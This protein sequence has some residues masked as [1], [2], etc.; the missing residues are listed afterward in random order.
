MYP[1]ESCKE[2]EL[3]PHAVHMPLPVED[4][5]EEDTLNAVAGC[6]QQMEW[7]RHRQQTVENPFTIRK[8]VPEAGK[9]LGV[10]STRL[11]L[12]GKDNSSDPTMIRYNHS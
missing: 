2:G 6:H 11:A 10:S 12:G 4:G 7:R 1:L 3:C 5:I 9:L 8:R